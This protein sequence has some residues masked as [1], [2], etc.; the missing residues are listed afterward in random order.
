[1][2]SLQNCE[3]LLHSE[4]N[5]MNRRPCRSVA[6]VLVF[7]MV[8]SF[9]WSN[10][11]NQHTEKA[12]IESSVPESRSRSDQ[13]SVSVEWT[14]DDLTASE[15][16]YLSKIQADLRER[17]AFLGSEI[18]KVVI[19]ADSI[20]LLHEALKDGKIT[21]QQDSLSEDDA[22]G[23]TI[24]EL[25]ANI[26]PKLAS[27]PNVKA[28]LE[29]E[30]PEAP[31]PKDF[32]QGP[33]SGDLPSPAMWQVTLTQGA[34]E[35]WGLGFEGEGVKVAVLDTGVDFAN[36]DLN[37]TQARVE[38]PGSPYFGWPITFDS[39]SM[40]RYLSTGNGFPASNNWFSDTSTTDA[41]S[42][43]DGFLDSSG[44]DI[45]T[46]VSQSG[47][48]H[49]GTHPDDYLR[50]RYG[51]YVGVLVVDSGVSGV[52]DSVYV[53][54][55]ND[56]SF[57]DEKAAVKGDE[58]SSHD[59][60]SDGL[61][62]RSGGMVYFIADGVNSVPYSD[63]ISQD[64]GVSNIIPT[65]GDLVTF[66][67]NDATESGGSHGTLC[68]SAIAA[69]GKIAGGA[70]VGMAPKAKIISVGNIYQG[71]NWWDNYVFAV[72]G[73]DGI[74]GT[75]DEANILSLSFGSS[76]SI[77]KGF[78]FSERFVD[79]ITTYYAPTATFM[80]AAGNGGFGYG[81]VITPGSSPGVVTVGASTSTW[82]AEPANFTTWGDVISWSDRGPS[83][84]GQVDPDILSVGAYGSGDVTLNQVNNANSA[85][86]IWGGTS[87]ATPVAAGIMS[88]IYESYNEAHGQYPSSVV[89]REIIMS[90][91]DN[92]HYDAVMQGAGIA[93]ASRAVQLAN[94]RYGV[95]ATP[96]FWTAGDYRGTH[97]DAFAN[98]LFPGDSD[99]FTFQVYNADQLNASQVSVSDEAHVRTRSIF[100][101][102]QSDRSLEDGYQG[103]RPDYLIPLIDN[104]SGLFEVPSGTDLVKVSVYLDYFEFDPDW[105]Y[106]I[107]NRYTMA[108]YDWWD[109]DGDGKYWN[110]V[111]VDGVVQ[112]DEIEGYPSYSEIQRFGISSQA[113]NRYEARVHDPYERIHDG[114]LVG[115]FHTRTTALVPITNVNV[116]VDTYELT[117]CSWLSVS[118]A[119]LTVP[120][121]GVSTFQADVNFPP[122]AKLGM[123]QAFVTLDYDTNQTAIPII[124]NL[125]SA[126]TDFL[127]NE[128]SGGLYDNGAVFGGFNWGWRYESGDWRYYFTEVPDG[129]FKPGQQLVANVSWDYVPTDIDVFLMGPTSDTF[130]AS[131]PDRYGPYT[132]ETKGRS[133]DTWIGGGRFMFDTITG[134]AQEI[135]AADL[136][137]GLWGIGLHN[138][139]NAGLNSTSN[140]SVDLGVIEMSPNPWDVG[141][142]TDFSNLIGQQMFLTNSTLN[143]PDLD[144]TAYGV[145][146]PIQLYNEVIMQDNPGDVTTSSWSYEIDIVNGGLLEASIDSAF[147]IDIDLYVLRDLNSNGVPNWGSEIVASSTSPDETELVTIKKP[148]N[149]KYWVFV[150]GYSVGGPSSNFDI[151]IDAIQGI[152]LQLSDLPTGPLEA[153]MPENFNASY[154]LP[155]LDGIYHGIIFAGPSYA[156]EVLS[157]R[158]YGEVLDTPPEFYAL[159]PPP[160]SIINDN[161]PMMGASFIDNGT[162]IDLSTVQMLVDGFNI[163]NL[164][165]ITPGLVTWATPFLLTEGL[166]WVNVSAK[167]NF[168]NYN[169][170]EWSFTVDTIPPYLNVISPQDGLVTSSSSVRVE[171]FT[172]VDADLRVNGISTVVL[173]N[174]SFLRIQNLVEGPNPISVVATDPA[175]NS[176]SVDLTITMD[177]IPPPLMVTEPS[178]G[179]WVNYPTVIVKGISE[180]GAIVSV[181]G[182][183]AIVQSDGSFE[184][185][186]A[187]ME[188]AN[189]INLTAEDEA[190]NS[191]NA[192]VIVNVDTIPPYLLVAS[193]QNGLLTNGMDLQVNG[194][195]EPSA[196]LTI[197]DIPTTV[198]LDGSFSTSVT[199]QSGQNDIFF[200]VTDLAG[201]TNNV[202]RTVTLDQTPPPLTVQAPI[203]GDISNKPFVQVQ[204]LT[205]QKA[206]LVVNG[207]FLQVGPTGDF[208]G[209]I[210]LADGNNLVVVTACDLAGNCATD[211]RNVFVDTESPNADAGKDVEILEGVEFFFDGSESSDNDQI[212]SY[213][214]TFRENGNEVEKEESNPSHVFSSVGLYEVTL[215]VTDRAGN[216]DEDVL[217]VKVIPPDDVDE[218]GIPDSWEIE[219]FGSIAFNPEDDPD[220]DY[221]NN[222]EEYLV[223]TNPNDSDTDGDGLKDGLDEDP[224]EKEGPDISDYWWVFV[225]VI[226]ILLVLILYITMRTRQTVPP[227]P[228][229]EVLEE[230]EP[231][232]EQSLDESESAEEET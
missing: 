61:A 90:S 72:E 50:I 108:I 56:L 112:Q 88:L 106:S 133:G 63:S 41:D 64:M 45:G 33:Y 156:K 225:V 113:A 70:V 166:H 103:T 22:M 177:T 128:S 143:L 24:L 28:I 62:D 66:A 131:Y 138:V 219:N 175:G 38:D 9:A 224:L 60:D 218:D 161:Q 213:D 165:T 55:D 105:D 82:T 222:Y 158:F 178:S 18:I 26:I 139:L 196:V 127:I 34:V 91:A 78:G 32:W 10:P 97:Y 95:E 79:E 47:V 228:D 168:G 12:D 134:G 77:N 150:H 11:S 89:S 191:A 59:L 35:A 21:V 171:G 102:I 212:D 7:L 126:N 124:A 107:E 54:L 17:V 149:G 201:N 226:V 231:V 86:G 110:D 220:L 152:D 216:S 75:G 183:L 136:T 232:T 202:L 207:Q 37:G 151:T 193:P 39:R 4:G 118:P 186:V 84:M 204:G 40:R 223:G 221:L 147:A 13:E 115:I 1:M 53:D 101:S 30:L 69:Q 65:N 181:G 169:S 104:K 52:Y 170:T 23:T 94:E 116:R 46:I 227:P 36:P 195:T 43:T 100:Y 51:S 57:A 215:H 185:P 99:N 81:T 120:A 114:L 71:G 208:D 74:P 146:Q 174:G 129:S 144:V 172:E 182:Q 96:S 42:N 192:Q 19:F 119:T 73:Y 68:A 209:L 200:N 176:K 210:P 5:F 229:D 29:Y 132:I 148:A 205:E 173:A 20:S 163:T 142:V 121:G 109:E 8:M 203:D 49:T 6:L 111:N 197:N 194:M 230:R 157:V 155:A 117:D 2:T 93:N 15:P 214:W 211:S 140:I 137:P 135:V 159:M 217:W 83:A 164:A 125:A 162:G 76:N 199:L 180:Q 80:A 27:L 154:T 190:G 167:D 98:I 85:W 187:L 141:L 145:S 206:S 44:Y 179:V 67:L 87:M 31:D 16:Q 198:Q 189:I 14:V 123:Y 184:V 160:G 48:Y 25:P 188:G 92:I 153:Y 3:W 122:D 130:S 58:V